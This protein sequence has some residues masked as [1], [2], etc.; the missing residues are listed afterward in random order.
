MS[1]E[2][3]EQ[4][5]TLIDKAAQNHKLLNDLKHLCVQH[6][7]FA[8]GSAF[9]TF[10]EICFPSTDEVKEIKRKI[11]EIVGCSKMTGLNI[12]ERAAYTIFRVIE[13]WEQKGT[14]FSIKDASKIEV[15]SQNLYP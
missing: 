6:N 5:V 13:I 8:I 1:T 14:Q 7:E 9:K 10:E 11:S 2:L 15:E 3:K 12:N 4:F